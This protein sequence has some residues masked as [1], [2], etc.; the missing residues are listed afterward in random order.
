MLQGRLEEL[1]IYYW[2]SGSVRFGSFALAEHRGR[3]KLPPSPYYL[4]YP[5]LQARNGDLNLVGLFDTAAGLLA[6]MVRERHLAF[7]HLAP[8]PEG[9]R[10]LVKALAQR[11]R[12]RGIL[13]FLKSIDCGQTVFTGPVSGDYLPNEVV[14]PVDDHISGGY[15]K[16]KFLMALYAAGLR[17]NDLLT[18][19]DREQGG[20][21]FLASRGIRLHS[22][23]TIT[24]LVGYYAYRGWISAEKAAEIKA[25]TA[26]N[27][28]WTA[29]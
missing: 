27:Q 3:P 12:H 11:L 7:H 6:D 25:Y 22:L 14:L 15:T 29:N 23:M 18:V 1:A 2:H 8:I 17:V 13:M 5:S 16:A 21:E 4:H 26:A 28:L 19:V 9:P 24:E 10:P 20:R